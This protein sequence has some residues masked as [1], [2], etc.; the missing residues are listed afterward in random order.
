MSEGRKQRFVISPVSL[1]EPLA[2]FLPIAHL[3]ADKVLLVTTLGSEPVATRVAEELKRRGIDVAETSPVS[4]TDAVSL[5]QAIDN[6]IA[7]AQADTLYVNA[8][9]GTKVMSLA[10]SIVGAH[11]KARKSGRPA[12]VSPVWGS[13]RS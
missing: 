9:P 13:D 6:G 10:V 3:K 5:Q 1:K 8:T 4:A 7:A 12:A 11:E 2:V